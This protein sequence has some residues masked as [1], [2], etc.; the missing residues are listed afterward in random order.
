[1]PIRPPPAVARLAGK[2]KKKN[3]SQGM[4]VV[5]TSHPVQVKESQGLGGIMSWG[6]KDTKN[7]TKW[8]SG[9]IGRERARIIIDG[10]HKR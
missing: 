9:V 3:G 7:E 5:P 10:S 8:E 1:M 6:K 2:E 4:G